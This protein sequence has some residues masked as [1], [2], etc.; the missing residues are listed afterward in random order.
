MERF[1]TISFLE[2]AAPLSVP[3]S[4]FTNSATGG[5]ATST[6]NDFD[7]AS[8]SS[9]TGTF[10]PLKVSVALFTSEITLP[11]LIPSGPSF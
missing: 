6:L 9:S 8:T 3:S 4:F 2:A 7:L 5:E 10:S 1:P 11:I